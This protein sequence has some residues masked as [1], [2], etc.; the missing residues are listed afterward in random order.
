MSTKFSSAKKTCL[1]LLF[2]LGML[3]SAWQT[4]C[5]MQTDELN[6]KE[7]GKIAAIKKAGKII[8]GTSADYPPYEFR[9]LPEIEDDF[10][11]IDMDIAEA[12]AA[13]LNVKLEIKNI[14]F[15]N[16]FKELEDGHIDLILAGLAPSESRQKMVDFSIPYYQAIQ[17]MLIRAKD[18]EQI[19]LLEDLRGKKVGTQSGSIQEDMAKSMI[20][21]ATFVTLPT[22]Q[23][24]ID[25]LAAQKLDAVILEKPVAD[26]YVFKNKDFLNLECNSNRTPLGSAAAVKKG[27]SE[28]LER[29]N[30]I[31]ERL[32]KENKINQFVQD[33]KVFTDKI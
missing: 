16:L 26:A 19:K 8:I 12:I 30:Q 14:V 25:G 20:F 1:G 27:N 2:I 22:I 31:L 11:G 17:N 32:I 21:G 7:P 4:G 24:L 23:A 18:S 29:I 13:D 33:A 15:N 28:L 10:V 6:K 3:A 5:R 9:L